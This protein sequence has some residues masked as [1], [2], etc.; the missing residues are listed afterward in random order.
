M[1]LQ[2]WNYYPSYVPPLL[3]QRNPKERPLPYL[4]LEYPSG[5][6]PSLGPEPREP[7]RHRFSYLSLVLVDQAEVVGDV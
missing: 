1:P 4:R 5:P 3:C 7:L 6:Q 2:C